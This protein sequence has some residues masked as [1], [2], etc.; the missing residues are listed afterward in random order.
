[1][2]S[3]LAF[4]LS[5]LPFVIIT[6]M[7]AFTVHE[8]AHAYTAYKFGDPTA[9]NQG[10][11]TLNPIQHLDPIGTILILIAGFGWARPVPVNR[12]H[13]KNPKLAGITVSIAGPLSNLLMAIL[14]FIIFY[15]LGGL[16]VLPSTPLFVI[17]FLDT[18]INLNLVLFVF[19]LLPLPPLDGYRI[20]E[21]LA[22]ANIRAKMTQFEVYGSLIFIILVIT[23]LGNYTIQPIFATVLPFLSQ[24]LDEFFYRL[25]MT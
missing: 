18:F 14:A 10:R 20:I 2:E 9:K 22:P 7:I 23:P 8:F 21:D 25:L 6:L 24:G 15:G 19:N 16:G 13:F 3:V 5:Q 1:M 4:P 12:Y 11:V 17:E